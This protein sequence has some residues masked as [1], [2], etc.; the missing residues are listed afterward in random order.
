M[1]FIKNQI[2]FVN[3]SGKSNKDKH[4]ENIEI[5]IL[6]AYHLYIFGKDINEEHPENIEISII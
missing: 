5:C 4:P 6:L 1:F 3:I 2:F